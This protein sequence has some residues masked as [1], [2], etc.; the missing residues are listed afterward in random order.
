M[1]AL[2][3]GAWIE[4]P[5]PP[6]VLIVAEVALH[7]GAWIET[8]RTEIMG[9]LKNLSPSMRGR[10]LKPTGYPISNYETY[11]ALHA[12]AWIE[13]LSLAP[14]IYTLTGRPPCGGVD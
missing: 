12:G 9:K 2:H 7:A 5:S 6:V 8:K 13:T 10:G 11:V 14:V 3:A 1:V 4:T